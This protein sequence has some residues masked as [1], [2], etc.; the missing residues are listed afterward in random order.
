MNNLISKAPQTP[1]E[2]ATLLLLMAVIV[3][4]LAYKA[5]QW[6]TNN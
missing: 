4:F 3:G 5:Y 1:I 6:V 2:N